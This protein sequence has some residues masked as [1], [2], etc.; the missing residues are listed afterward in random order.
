MARPMTFFSHCILA[1]LLHYGRICIYAE[2]PRVLNENSVLEHFSDSKTVQNMCIYILPTHK[3]T[4][5]DDDPA[6][7]M[8]RSENHMALY[9][10][11]VV[12]GS[13]RRMRLNGRALHA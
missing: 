5:R 13:C 7:E 9:C 12:S 6:R 11:P 8:C 1:A 2:K 3:N 10:V 4:L